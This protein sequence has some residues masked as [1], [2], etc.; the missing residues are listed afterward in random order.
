MADVIINGNWRIWSVPSIANIAAPTTTELNAGVAYEMLLTPDGFQGFA[1]T[2]N[3]VDTSPLGGTFAT[4][5]PGTV[6]FGDMSLTFKWQSGVDTI[7]NTL[8][9]NYA[10][11]IVVRRRVPRATAWTSGQLLQVY[12]IVCGQFTPR[13]Y[14][15]NV[16]DTFTVPVG[17]SL[18]PELRSVIA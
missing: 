17:P 18:A 6:D 5:Q 12:P 11:N 4:K 14:E 13:D 3:W 10:T 2:T 9:I 16:V 7:F 8:V 1:T 15:S